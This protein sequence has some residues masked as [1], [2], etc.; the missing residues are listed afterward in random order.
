MIFSSSNKIREQKSLLGIT[1]R[2]LPKRQIKEE[3]VIIMPTFR[4]SQGILIECAYYPGNSYRASVINH[5]LDICNFIIIN[6]NN[7][8]T[9]MYQ[10]RQCKKWHTS[11]GIE[12][13]H[14]VA[15]IQG[16]S[17]HL[18]NLQILCTICNRA[19]I[20]H[21]GTGGISSRTRVQYIVRRQDYP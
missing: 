1:Y 18:G 11:A 14:I 13:D 8:H 10:C 19:D 2:Y 20:H 9:P 21:V 16:G 5:A 6:I 17:N 15:Q 3:G 4:S 12:G 7:V